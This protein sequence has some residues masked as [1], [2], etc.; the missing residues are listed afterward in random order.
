MQNNQ[1]FLETEKLYWESKGLESE[2]LHINFDP[3]NPDKSVADSIVLLQNL[4]ERLTIIKADVDDGITT[5][6]PEIIKNLSQNKHIK[7]EDI[8]EQPPVS[9]SDG[10]SRITDLLLEV[11]NLVK[12]IMLAN[13]ILLEKSI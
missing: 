7:K 6:S 9:L 8:I 10:F 11:S 3:S 12:D 1:N 2:Y 13:I 5:I 4:K